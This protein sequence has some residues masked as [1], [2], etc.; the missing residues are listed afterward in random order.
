MQRG[1]VIQLQPGSEVEPAKFAGHVEHVDTGRAKRFHSIE[2]LVRF[3]EQTLAEIKQQEEVEAQSTP[4]QAER[5]GE[6]AV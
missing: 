2:E 1:F 5:V 4:P 3:M 6:E